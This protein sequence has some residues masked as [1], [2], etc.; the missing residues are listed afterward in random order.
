MSQSKEYRGRPGE[1][2][3][4]PCKGF[5]ESVRPKSH[6]TGAIQSFQD[7]KEIITR[8]PEKLAD[9]TTCLGEESLA[10]SCAHGVKPMQG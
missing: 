8:V 5:M 2:V 3:S 10:Q 1:Y 4:Q 9:W 7:R 6:T